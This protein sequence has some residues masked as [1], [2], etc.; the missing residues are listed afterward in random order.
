[1]RGTVAADT[2][3]DPG[4]LI[5]STDLADP[6]LPSISRP[7]TL[8][9]QAYRALRRAIRQ[10]ILV[11]GRVYSEGQIA[12][13][14]QISR[15]PVREALIELTRQGVTAKLAQQGFRL[16]DVGPRERTEVYHLRRAIETYIVRRLATEATDE[17]IAALRHVMS[18]QES[19]KDARPF[20][21]VAFTEAGEAFHLAMPSLIGLERSAEILETLRGVLWVS[22]VA[23]TEQRGRPEEAL[24]E[25]RE[26][27]RA[28]AAREPDAAERA[29]LTHLER[30]V[31]VAL[32]GGADRSKEE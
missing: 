6:G 32:Q 25:H 24:A 17:Q 11:K 31:E 28:V 2:I 12:R 23:I 16:R 27:V 13:M 14:L 21:A 15:T 7:E 3:I 10:G 19:L 4:A 1:M 20:D 5:A 22:G 8:A 9:R 29:V 26:I 30:T 18:E